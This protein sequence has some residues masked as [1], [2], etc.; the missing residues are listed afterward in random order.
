[1][2]RPPLPP[3]HRPGLRTAGLPLLLALLLSLLPLPRADAAAAEPGYVAL[4]DSFAA[5]VGSRSYAPDDPCLRSP[6]SYPAL[7]A[8]RYDLALTHAACSGAV[9]ADVLGQQVGALSAGTSRISVTVGGNDVGFTS[10]LTTCAL[11]GWLGNCRRA[12]DASRRA[13]QGVLPARL[14]RVLAAVRQ[15]SPGAVVV[16]TGYPKLFG[17]E[18]CSALTFFSTDDRRRLNAATDVLDAVMEDRAAAAGVSYTDAVPAFR[19]HA[20]CD[21]AAWVNGP[22]RPRLNSYHPNVA[23][24]AAYARLVGPLVGRNLPTGPASTSRVRL[25]AA[26]ARSG[27]GFSVPDLDSTAVRRASARAGV[28]PAELARLRRAQ[29]SGADQASLDRLDATLTRR[30]AERRSRQPS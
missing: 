2:R 16:V 11:P 9:T 23:G 26:T 7:V 10:V 5:G 22:S 29:R 6:L 18:D 13:M 4:G 25:P 8:D 12:V 24:H 20:W 27:D 17:D 19:G 21:G 1:M 28:S 30:A 3:R 14:D 15:R